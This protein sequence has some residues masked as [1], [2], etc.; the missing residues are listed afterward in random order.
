MQGNDLGTDE[1]FTSG[2]AAWYVE[3]ELAAVGVQVIR[4]PVVGRDETEFCYL[5]PVGSGAV[6]GQGIVDL[7]HVDD[8]RA[9][10]VSTNSFSGASAISRLLMHFN[11][12]S[13][14]GSH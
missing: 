5:E 13:S 1:V 7:G 10:V 2:Q 6:R 14:T 11:A 3:G 8:D 4:S 9:I 12:D